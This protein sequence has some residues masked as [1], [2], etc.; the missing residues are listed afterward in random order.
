[1]FVRALVYTCVCVCF[2]VRF[3]MV[4]RKVRHTVTSTIGC[5][6]ISKRLQQDHL[7][8]LKG[9]PFVVSDPT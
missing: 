6:C 8:S 4:D 7:T 2:R 5:L 3:G 9:L 1:M